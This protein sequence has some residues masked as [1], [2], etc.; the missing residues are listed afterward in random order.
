MNCPFDYVYGQASQLVTQ[1]V[2]EYMTYVGNVDEK[3]IHVLA[4]AMH[5]LFLDMPEEF[6]SLIKRLNY[7]MTKPL[8]EG[9]CE[10]A[11]SEL[12]D[13]FVKS[14]QSGFDDGAGFSLEVEGKEVLN[15][16]GGFT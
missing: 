1:E 2:L 3:N 5:H 6:I 8:V 14:I 15:L 16:W 11:F 4:G 12:K 10:P 13:I 9:F 7:K